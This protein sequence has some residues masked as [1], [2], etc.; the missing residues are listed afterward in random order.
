MKCNECVYESEQGSSYCPRCGDGPQPEAVSQNTAAMT[1]L[2]ALKDNLFLVL[3]ILMSA[4]CILSLSADN[5]PLISI[6]TTVFLWLVYAQSRK[7]ITDAKQ[8]RNVSGTIYAQ[9]VLNNVLAIIL[10]VVGVIFAVA[11]GMIAESPEIMDA[12]YGS[13]MEIDESSLVFAEVL[14][15]GAGVIIL[16]VFAI[17]AIA[18]GIINIFSLRYIH[19]FAKSVY[20]S[21]QTGVLELKHVGATRGWLIVFA[22]CSGIGALSALAV[23]GLVAS[24]SSAISC[25]VCII[26]VMLINKYLSSEK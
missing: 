22:V 13:L 9:Y 8:L 24:L 1:V 25:A 20:Q 26:A 6:L 4:S 11:F 3:C 23:D 18:I 19:R 7:D 15:A 14:H 5:L 2:A 16:V 12:L 10:L 21:I 17:A